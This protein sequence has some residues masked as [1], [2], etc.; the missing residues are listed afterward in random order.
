MLEV[1]V[2]HN[3]MG[4]RKKA[5]N[6]DTEDGRRA[7]EAMIGK[8]MNE[9]TAI[10]LE[11]GKKTYRLTGYSAKQNRLR[12]RVERRSGKSATV[13]AKPEKGRKT[14]IAPVAGG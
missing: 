5:F 3:T 7:A 9:G 4:D 6:T 11:R 8:M 1:D 13:N 14:A 2:L 12:V 10:F